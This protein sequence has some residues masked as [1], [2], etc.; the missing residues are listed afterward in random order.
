MTAATIR[1]SSDFTGNL[2]SNF[3]APGYGEGNAFL[4][5]SILIPITGCSINP[6][7]SIGPAIVTT[8]LDHGDTTT[9]WE[10]QWIFWLG[11]LVG[12]ALAVVVYK[13]LEC[14]KPG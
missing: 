8:M 2:A 5:H 14:L 11:P 6:T 10:D 1:K 13:L 3:V 9:I 7:R 12:A 4:G